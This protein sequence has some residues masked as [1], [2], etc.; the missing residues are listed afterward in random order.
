MMEKWLH[1]GIHA[2]T[3]VGNVWSNDC[4][5]YVGGIIVTGRV[6]QTKMD[7]LAHQVGGWASG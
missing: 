5:S 2:V 1:E 6:W 4:E 7:T 3:V